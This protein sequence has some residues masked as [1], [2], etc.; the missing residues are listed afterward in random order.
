[1][2]I[3]VVTT[4]FSKKRGW[5][6]LEKKI[7][8]RALLASPCVSLWESR[9][10]GRR[11]WNFYT[12]FS[13]HISPTSD[14]EAQRGAF[15]ATQTNDLATCMHIA[16]FRFVI[17][18]PTAEPSGAMVYVVYVIL[19]RTRRIN[20]ILYTCNRG[21]VCVSIY[22][23]VL[24]YIY[25]TLYVGLSRGPLSTYDLLF[26]SHSHPSLPPFTLP[27]FENLI[28]IL[29]ISTQIFL[30]TDDSDR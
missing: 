14:G 16:I 2:Y 1:M 19:L 7:V 15:D 30:C 25:N 18:T 12:Y 8:C 17:A 10:L 24:L 6:G 9:R 13:S 21:C 5:K 28:W 3:Y 23:H 20:I 4:G 27:C 11:R 29:R 22:L 26:P